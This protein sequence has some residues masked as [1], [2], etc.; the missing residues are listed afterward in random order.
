LNAQYS[1]VKNETDYL[2]KNLVAAAKNDTLEAQGQ[3]A[4]DA[5]EEAKQNYDENEG[6]ILTL[7]DSLEFTKNEVIKEKIK[8][9]ISDL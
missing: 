7:R 3:A 6:K 1:T 8:Q 9:R 4:L 5:M 2:E